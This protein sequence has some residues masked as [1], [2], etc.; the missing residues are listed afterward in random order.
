MALI[1][2]S[3]HYKRGYG[4]QSTAVKIIVADA[5]RA[6]ADAESALHQELSNP[7]LSGA[8]HFF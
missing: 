6:F 5:E 7:G 3:D 8:D 2:N 1:R 4:K